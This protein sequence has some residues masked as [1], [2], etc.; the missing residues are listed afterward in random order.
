MATANYEIEHCQCGHEKIKHRVNAT[1][2]DPRRQIECTICPCK[3]F[4][5]AKFT[6]LKEGEQRRRITED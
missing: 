4:E 6:N 2:R 1:E 5:P 3:T